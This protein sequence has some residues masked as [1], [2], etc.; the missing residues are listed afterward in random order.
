MIA[1]N[2]DRQTTDTG[3]RR[4]VRHEPVA[5][6][7]AQRELIQ[8]IVRSQ[9]FGRSERLSALL[10]YVCEMVHQGR[11]AEINEQRIGQAVFER[12]PD[13][14]S[15]VDGIVRSQASRLRQR[16]ELYFQ[17]EGANE[18]LRVMI[19]RGGYVPVFETWSNPK[20][21]EDLTVPKEPAEAGSTPSRPHADKTHGGL[22]KGRFALSLGIGLFLIASGAAAWFTYRAQRVATPQP[23]LS[24]L[25]WTD[26]LQRSP[27][28]IVVA[29]DSGLVLFH[30]LTDHTIDLKAYLGAGYR[31]E[32]QEPPRLRRSAQPDLPRELAN[33]RYTS[34]VDVQAI[35]NLK[36]RAHSVSSN[37]GVRF[38]RDLR[39]ND[40]KSGNVVLLGSSMANP[41]VELYEHNMNFVLRD[42]R[43]DFVRVENRNPNAGEPAQWQ[44][45]TNESERR[46]YGVVAYTAGLEGKGNALI[47]EGA[48]M[49][50]TEA[51]ADFVF[52]DSRFIPFLQ[53]VR[54]S[55]GSLRHFELVLETHS[56]GASAVQSQIVAWRILD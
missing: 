37:I 24:Q 31:S 41:W 1:N 13:Y 26:L 53:K 49:S 48:T 56:M 42:G 44:S 23:S 40:L 25:F 3:L 11:E 15:S 22:F 55:D 39:P 35:L 17:T 32:L 4:S 47:L 45:P 43:R 8:R 54:R 30:G 46:L 7:A 18:S 10:T 28:T 14:D 6:R 38:A 16:L 50:G 2:Q 51:A 12:A 5:T 20:D 29:P 27:E 34:M 36:D 52:E 33:R 9:T 19:P 21:E